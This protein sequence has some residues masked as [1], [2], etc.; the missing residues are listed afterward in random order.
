MAK[1]RRGGPQAG[2]G[3]ALMLAALIAVFSLAI[4][5]GA[6][7]HA[8][9]SWSASS[10]IATALFKRLERTA[11]DAKD[12]AKDLEE[13]GFDKK[14]IK[15][16]TDLKNRDA[17]EKEF[18]AFLKTSRAGTRSSSFS[19]ATASGSR[20]TRPTTVVHRSQ[21]PVHLHQDATHRSERKNADIVR[22]RIPSFWMPISKAKFPTASPRPRSRDGWRAQ[23]QNRHHDPGCLPLA[24]RGRLNDAQDKPVKRGNDSGSRLL[25]RASA[26]GFMVFYSASFGEQAV[27]KLGVFDTGRNSCSPTSCA[28]SC[29]VPDSRWSSSPIASS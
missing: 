4:H 27:E 3:A 6:A 5:G 9:P 12:V 20:R 22:L 26:P 13:V 28:P 1:S 10:A 14:N 29:S 18:S 25:P 19:P 21:E 2:F 17:F 11:N 7:E 8:A 15:V 16:V 24:G 23:S